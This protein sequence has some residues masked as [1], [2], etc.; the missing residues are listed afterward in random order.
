MRAPLEPLGGFARQALDPLE[1]D[2]K[3]DDS[4]HEREGRS[5]VACEIGREV[6]DNGR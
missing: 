5:T 4:G 3:R 6:A 1:A 2:S